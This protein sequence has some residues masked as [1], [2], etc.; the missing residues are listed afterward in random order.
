MLSPIVDYLYSKKVPRSLS[1]AL[2]YILFLSTIIILILISYRPLFSQLEEFIRILPDLV[3]N[4]V[5]TIIIRVPFIRDR[6]NWE[7]ILK[8]LKEN[9]WANLEISNISNYF[10]SGVGKAFGFV[11]SI[12]GAFINVLATIIISVYFIHSKEQSKEKLLKFFPTKHKDRIYDIMNKIETQLGAWL[13]AQLILMAII[14]FLGWLGLEIIGVEFSVPMGIIGG[15][16]ETIP[17]IGP[18][19]TWVLAVTIGI[20]SNLPTWK[21]VFIAIWFILIQQVENY[22]IIPKLMEKFVG[23]NP[24]LTILAVLGASKIFGVWGAL[25]AVPTVAILQISLREYL[26]YKKEHE[27]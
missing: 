1:I 13:R 27:T 6:F 7:E 16:L 18:M 15:L 2:I 25:L 11:G 9:F 14:G 23:T 21:I 17:N 3:V 22:I 8:N 19:I 24:L 26:K 10:I 5:N 20:G 12:F 4:V